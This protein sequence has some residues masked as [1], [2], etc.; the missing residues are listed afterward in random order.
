MD[1]GVRLSF[2]MSTAFPFKLKGRQMC[3]RVFAVSGQACVTVKVTVPQAKAT[4][5]AQQRLSVAVMIEILPQQ[6]LSALLF[7]SLQQQRLL[8]LLQSMP[9]VPSYRE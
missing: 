4:Q 8:L 5:G 1:L 7:L 6:V 9:G 2:G 3:Q